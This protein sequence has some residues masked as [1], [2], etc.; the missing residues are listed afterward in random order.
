[1]NVNVVDLPASP[2]VE[3][4]TSAG[5]T[6][7]SETDN[8]VVRAATDDDLIE[9]A[10]SAKNGAKFA[11]LWRGE[12]E[13]L[14]YPSQSEADQAL[15]NLLAFWWNS[16]ATAIGCSAARLFIGQSGTEGRV[17]IAGER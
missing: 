13:D 12:W 3:R 6:A 4:L 16:D 11:A 2:E 5:P 10:K 8:I 17:T 15:A 1:M 14:G 7:A 9:M